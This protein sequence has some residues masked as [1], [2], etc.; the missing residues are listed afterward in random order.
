MRRSNN[1]LSSK[2]IWREVLH[3]ELTYTEILENRQKFLRKP[4][5]LSPC[6]LAGGAFLERRTQQAVFAAE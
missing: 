4:V 3:Y 2:P 1:R 6:V 5:F